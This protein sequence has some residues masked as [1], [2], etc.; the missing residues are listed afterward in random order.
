MNEI[1]RKCNNYFYSFKER[2]KY[3]IANNTITVRGKYRAGNYIRIMGS[4]FNDGI[5]EV[6]GFLNGVVSVADELFNEEVELGTIC[7]LVPPQDFKDIVARIVEAKR[8]YK[9]KEYTSQSVEGYSETIN[10]VPTYVQLEVLLLPYASM[11]DG[12]AYVREI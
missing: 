9:P 12:F 8:E 1:M 6:V 5:Y 2:G 7:S 10:Q 4:M 11:T 3:T